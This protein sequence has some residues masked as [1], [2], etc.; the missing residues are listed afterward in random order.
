MF[1]YFITYRIFKIFCPYRGLSDD[2][3]T[4]NEKSVE[5]PRFFRKYKLTH[6]LTTL[7][8]L[9]PTFTSVIS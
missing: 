9:E 6:Y 2:T 7:T 8:T 5:K 4:E 1:T 3:E